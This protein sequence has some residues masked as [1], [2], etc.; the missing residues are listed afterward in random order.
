MGVYFRRV[1]K[2][3]K[4]GVWIA[5][6]PLAITSVMLAGVAVGRGRE[7]E[8]A[9]MKLLK[10]SKTMESLILWREN[11]KIGR[12]IAIEAKTALICG[13]VRRR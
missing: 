1:K 10:K 5:S 4:S 13:T 12:S 2:G 7:V 9:P 11:H 8:G 6:P 3:L